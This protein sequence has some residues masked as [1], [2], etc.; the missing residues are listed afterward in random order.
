MSRGWISFRRLVLVAFFVGVG[1]NRLPAMLESTFLYFPTHSDAGTDLREWRVDGKLIGYSFP[2][3]SPKMVWL[4]FHGNAGQARDRGYV[5]RSLPSSD[6]VY[7]VEYPGYGQREGAPSMQSINAAAVEAYALLR[8]L[9]PGVPIGVI[10][11]S[12]GSGPASYL[13]SLANPPARAVLIV[14][15]DNLLSLAKE[16]MPFLPVSLLL[17]DRWDNAAALSKYAGRID[18]YGALQD[19][20]IPV[21]HARQLA[22]SLPRA[23]YHEVDC[24][25][26][27][28]SS[29][30]HLKIGE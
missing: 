20:I 29:S 28:W 3:A 2:V 9:Y 16:H 4:M 27:D 13:C 15:F 1:V 21:H 26:N 12:L 19:T 7:I 18:I 10:G 23:V 24:G 30:G 22:Q 5:R 6:A 8:T 14:P 17:R 11:E 25:H